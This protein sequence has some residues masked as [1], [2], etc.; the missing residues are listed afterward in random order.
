MQWYRVISAVCEEELLYTLEDPVW[1]QTCLRNI[2]E[3]I[4]D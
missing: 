2:F 4:F 1:V 3:M